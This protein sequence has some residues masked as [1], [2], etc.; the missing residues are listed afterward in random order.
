MNNPRFYPLQILDCKL[1][2][3]TEEYKSP[4][5]TVFETLDKT[6]AQKVNGQ[7]VVE[8][9]TKM[10]GCIVAALGFKQR[11]KIEIGTVQKAFSTQAYSKNKYSIYINFTGSST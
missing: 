5:E 9:S 2:H 10:V 6:K 7:Y 11:T 8:Y 3:D 4:T 1:K